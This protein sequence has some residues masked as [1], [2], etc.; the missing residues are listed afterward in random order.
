MLT[1][2]RLWIW[3]LLGAIVTERRGAASLLDNF[4]DWSC[5]RLE[6]A[7]DCTDVWKVFGLSHARL[8]TASEAG[9]LD[10]LL[11]AWGVT[12]AVRNVSLSVRKG[13]NFCIMGLSGS[14]KST[15]VRCMTGLLPSTR[16]SLRVLGTDLANASADE[17]IALRRLEISMVF[18]DF[19]LLPH[20][21]VLENVAF[22]LRVRGMSRPEREAKAEQVVGMVG[23]DGRESY[24]PHELSG[25]QQQRVGIARSLVTDPQLWFLD[26]PFSALD[27]IIRQ[28]MQDELL[29]LQARLKKTTIFITHDFDEALR[30]A[31][32]I[33]IMKD[34]RVVQVGTPEELVLRPADSYV[35]RFTSKVALAAVVRVGSVMSPTVVDASEEVLDSSMLIKD[36]APRVL[37]VGRALPVTGVGGEIVGSLEPQAVASLLLGRMVRRGG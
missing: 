31:S 34:G 23:L 27:P 36:A 11:E 19:A 12:P 13:E 9:N 16:G 17:L 26:E 37:E 1:P 30:L 25:G 3:A 18:Q 21:T 5:V 2:G 7:L 35:A 29:R 15:L 28:D 8:K 20:L 24:Y 22:P 6:T 33:A 32:R 14:G 10:T 4:V